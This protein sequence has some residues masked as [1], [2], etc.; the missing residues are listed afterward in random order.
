[1]DANRQTAL[2][3]MSAQPPE[4]DDAFV[5]NLTSSTTPMALSR[6]KDPALDQFKF[7]VSRRREDGRER[8]RLHMGYFPSLAAA[9]EWLAVV[10]EVY[11]SAWA[12]EAPGRKLKDAKPV[13]ATAPALPKSPPSATSAP[14]ATASSP[15]PAKLPAAA[16]PPVAAK[17]TVTVKIVAP[18]APASKPPVAK[19]SSAPTSLE[20]A[21]SAPRAKPVGQSPPANVPTVQP[22]KIAA[23]AATPPATAKVIAR[24]GAA[25]ATNKPAAPKKLADAARPTAAAPTPQEP[26]A[27]RPAA[28]AAAANPPAPHKVEAPAPKQSNIREVIAELDQLSD[29]A[30]LRVLEGRSPAKNPGGSVDEAI[31]LVKP[32]DTQTML[33]IKADV[34]R[35]APVSFAVQLEWSVQPIDMKKVPPLAIF[36]AYTLYATE[37]S[38]DGRRWYALRLG[39]FSDAISAKQVAYYVRSDFASVAVVPVSS[40]EKDRAD[41]GASTKAA[42]AKA[43]APPAPSQSGVFQLLEDDTPPPI[44]LDV[45][46]ETSPRKPK[47]AEARAAV[48]SDKTSGTQPNKPRSGT[49]LPSQPAKAKASPKK[50]DETL[51]ILGA[52]D[53]E[54]DMGR[55]ELLSE[56]GVRHLRVHVD[57]RTSKF[58]SLLDRIASKLGRS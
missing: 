23:K 18:T 58:T 7:F 44:E 10:R 16:K 24:S 28:P 47:A 15:T 1:M 17:P 46:G 35:K 37:G 39:F 42:A 11:P 34:Q 3:M 54:F 2:P 12:G 43:D 29:T 52:D 56:S 25:V 30:T 55:G 48:P 32:E 14:T 38:K 19:R 5:I 53:L 50:L 31:R 21:P 40:A 57:K 33:A 49:R 22:A 45:I 6:P 9:E 26:K 36:N 4:S 20:L 51:E 41:G 27:E 13:E 8:F